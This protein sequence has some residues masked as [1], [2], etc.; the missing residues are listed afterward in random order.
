MSKTNREIIEEILFPDGKARREKSPYLQKASE[1]KVAFLENAV[2]KIVPG[3]ST[4]E[5]I[6]ME[7]YNKGKKGII[8]TETGFADSSFNLLISKKDRM[9]LLVHFADIKGV[10]LSKTDKYNIDIVY[11]DGIS[12]EAYC[13]YREYVAETVTRILESLNKRE[14]EKNT[15]PVKAKKVTTKAKKEPGPKETLAV[16]TEEVKSPAAEKENTAPKKAASKRKAVSPKGKTTSEN[17][18]DLLFNSGLV[19]YRNKEYDLAYQIFLLAANHGQVTAMYYVGICSMEGHGTEKDQNSAITWLGK[20]AEA[21]NQDAEKWLNSQSEKASG[22]EKKP[23]AEPKAKS[24]PKEKTAEELQRED[25][26]ARFSEITRKLREQDPQAMFDYALC[27]RDGIEVEKNE[28]AFLYYLIISESKGYDKAKE[29]LRQQDAET[30]FDYGEGSHTLKLYDQ[31]LVFLF[32]AANMGY[33]KAYYLMGQMVRNGEGCDKDEDFAE[34][35]FKKAVELGDEEARA[36][37][38]KQKEAVKPRAA[39][40]KSDLKDQ[41]GPIPEIPFIIPE[42]IAAKYNRVYG[43]N[44]TLDQVM[45]PK[46]REILVRELHDDKVDLWYKEQTAFEKAISDGNLKEAGQI[47]AKWFKDV[48]GPDKN[49]HLWRRFAAAAGAEEYVYA[50]MAQYYYDEG[51]YDLAKLYAE[52]EL[53]YSTRKS[54]Q[55]RIEKAREILKDID[56]D[57]RNPVEKNQDEIAAQAAYDEAMKRPLRKSDLEGCVGRIPD[58]VPPREDNSTLWD[59]KK[60]EE[61]ERLK[62]S[63]DEAAQGSLTDPGKA[64]LSMGLWHLRFARKKELENS[65]HLKLAHLWCRHAALAGDYEA[66]RVLARNLFEGKGTSKNVEIAGKYAELYLKKLKRLKP[67]LFE[68]SYTGQEKNGIV[69]CREIMK[70]AGL[71]TWITAKPNPLTINRS[72]TSWKSIKGNEFLLDEDDPARRTQ[73][74]ILVSRGFSLFSNKYMDEEKRVLDTEIAGKSEFYMYADYYAEKGYDAY[75]KKEYDAARC[76]FSCAAI[77]GEHADSMYRLGCM[78]ADGKGVKKN[79]EKAHLYFSSAAGQHSPEGEYELAK[80]FFYGRGTEKDVLLAEEY[81]RK[82]EQDGV[83]DASILMKELLPEAKQAAAEK[84]R[85]EEEAKKQQAEKEEKIKQERIAKEE[86]EKKAAEERKKKKEEEKNRILSAPRPSLPVY[87]RKLRNNTIALIGAEGS[88]K[89]ELLDALLKYMEKAG[90]EVKII[91]DGIDA[92]TKKHVKPAI[93]EAVLSGKKYTFLLL[94]SDPKYYRNAVSGFYFANMVIYAISFLDWVHPTDTI[95]RQS[96]DCQ[97]LLRYRRLYKV[98]PVITRMDWAADKDLIEIVSEEI[99]EEL[100][101]IFGYSSLSIDQIYE[102]DIPLFSNS[103]AASDVVQK[104]LGSVLAEIDQRWEDS[105]EYDKNSPTFIT[106]NAGTSIYGETYVEGWMNNGTIRKGDELQLYGYSAKPKNI[107]CGDLE[108]FCASAEQAF[109]DDYV[110]IQIS[111]AEAKE[112]RCG[113]VLA[114][115]GKASCSDKI[116]AAIDFLTPKEGGYSK[117]IFQHSRFQVMIG[118]MQAQGEIIFTEDLLSQGVESLYPGDT[119][120]LQLN[121]DRPIP[122]EPWLRVCLCEGGMV[123]VGRVTNVLE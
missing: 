16:I 72:I 2:R 79:F 51:R 50:E 64:F 112:L 81:A 110:R 70:D 4:S 1:F 114:L 105:S 26:K 67:E 14:E 77:F 107:R 41:E 33:A 120:V 17:S 80:D 73:E 102:G 9:P 118:P 29:L 49:V 3:T 47:A 22:T 76:C 93:A 10:Y 89:K 35:L 6:A 96:I 87:D 34:T 32:A 69:L 123:A 48:K 39:S 103:E 52:K 54:L 83:K 97:N 46:V 5:I 42:K 38:E 90:G 27:C 62:L 61:W 88:E 59:N 7:S 40:F 28:S 13:Y 119:Y 86:A 44:A 53:D 84:Q 11:K 66:Y 19:A 95:R 60:R 111:G 71:A 113:Q 31:A 12:R 106:L 37:L 108:V 63:A 116:E 122:V 115:P 18:L 23:K 109:T 65:A 30:V 25:L 24:E 100:N 104:E 99:K 101:D 58:Y 78:Y 75:K 82:A 92:A 21:G 98:V 91:S 85:L 74:K 117:N 36:E 68:F 94:P 45:Q 55:N 15:V 57:Q 20:A 56:F 121:L 8:F 43:E